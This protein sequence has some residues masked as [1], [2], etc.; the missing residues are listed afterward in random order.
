[1]ESPSGEN[2]IVVPVNSVPGI[3]RGS[4]SSSVRRK[5][6]AELTIIEFPSGETASTGRPPF[7]GT[8]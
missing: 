8:S 3:I 4:R 6:P 7:L 2:M 5:I 1:M